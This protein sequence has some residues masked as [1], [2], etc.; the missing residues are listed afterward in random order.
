[1]PQA[2]FIA[3]VG[4]G[5][6]CLGALLAMLSGVVTNDYNFQLNE[7]TRQLDLFKFAYPESVEASKTFPKQ[8]GL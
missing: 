6:T 7:T 2:L 1:M 8:L 5:G 4:L 3:L